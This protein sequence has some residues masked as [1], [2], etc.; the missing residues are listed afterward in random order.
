MYQGFIFVKANPQKFPVKTVVLGAGAGGAHADACSFFV[1][2]VRH[3]IQEATKEKAF[4]L[5]NNKVNAITNV[6]RDFSQQTV[7][8]FL[9]FSTVMI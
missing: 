7:L 5:K 1:E 3:K 6:K 8:S 2:V 4:L 9:L